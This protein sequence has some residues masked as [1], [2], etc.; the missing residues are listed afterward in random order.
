M[1]A[2]GCVGAGTHIAVQEAGEV[3]QQ[4]GHGPACTPQVL[5]QDQRLHRCACWGRPL[6]LPA[7]S[8]ALMIPILLADVPTSNSLDATRCACILVLSECLIHFHLQHISLCV[9]AVVAALHAA[10]QTMEMCR[11][12]T[13][14]VLSH[15]YCSMRRSIASPM[16][17]HG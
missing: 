15:S 4:A 8:F 11:R 16:Q 14:V 12:G 3:E 7:P 13:C 1:A 5:H 17:E 6:C 2:V 10:E 9:C